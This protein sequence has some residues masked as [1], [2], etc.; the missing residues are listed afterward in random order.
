MIVDTRQVAADFAGSGDRA[1]RSGRTPRSR[2]S[3][4][5]RSPNSSICTISRHRFRSATTTSSRKA[6]WQFVRCWPVWAREQNLGPGMEPRQS[7]MAARRGDQLL[8]PVMARINDE[9][10]NLDWLRPQWHE[11]DSRE[12][13]AEE[14]DVAARTFAFRG[15]PQAGEDHGSYGVDPCDD[16]PV[17]FRQ[18]ERRCRCR[19]RSHAHAGPVERRG[20]RK[21]VFP[22]R[23][24][25]MPRDSA[26]PCP[27]LGKKYFVTAILKLTG[28]VNRRIDELAGTLPKQVDAYADQVQPLLAGIQERSRLMPQRRLRRGTRG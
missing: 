19:G 27:P 10:A 22:S 17:I 8:G 4:T 6:C 9:F 24:R 23:M 13:S 26:L 18:T 16:G 11:L 25:P 5:S 20:R 2:P 3:R 28:I 14:L 1:A 15:G 7:P 12:F 21:C